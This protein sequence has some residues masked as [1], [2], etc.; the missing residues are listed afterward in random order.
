MAK[1][2]GI[3]IGN[4]GYEDA[5]SLYREA[6]WDAKKSKRSING[7]AQID[8]IRKFTG[9]AGLFEEGK[10]YSKAQKALEGAKNYLS[11]SH[12]GGE[13]NIRLEKNIES[14]LKKIEGKMPSKR[15][16]IFVNS[17]FVFATF[18]VVSLLSALFFISFD[19]TG[20][21]ILGDAQTNLGFLAAGLFMLGL[22]FVFLYFK[23]KNKF[24]IKKSK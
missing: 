22:V 18:A 5:T 24:L 10:N 11:D 7:P 1:R 14:R 8:V 17:P 19:L 15:K 16:G 12:I 23:S 6:V 13:M 4:T 2:Y 9:A 21:I 3:D 20:N